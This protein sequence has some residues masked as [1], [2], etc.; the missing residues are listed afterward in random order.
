MIYHFADEFI[1]TGQS[2][3]P[4]ARRLAEVQTLSPFLPFPF[5]FQPFSSFVYLTSFRLTL[6]IFPIFIYSFF[7]FFIFPICGTFATL[8]DL[9]IF[10]RLSCLISLDRE[11]KRKAIRGFNSIKQGNHQESAFSLAKFFFFFYTEK[12]MQQLLENKFSSTWVMASHRFSQGRK[13]HL[14]I[15]I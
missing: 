5:L 4:K 1:S 6:L 12:E 9:R 8:M 7:L 11:I 3:I 13:T 10:L 15:K 2:Q 14:G